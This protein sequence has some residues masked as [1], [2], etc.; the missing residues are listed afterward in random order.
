MGLNLKTN[1]SSTKGAVQ[2]CPPV[3]ALFV[4]LVVDANTPPGCK[5][6]SIRYYKSCAKCGIVPEVKLYE[7]YCRILEHVGLP[8]C[9]CV[10]SSA[11]GKPSALVIVIG[12][13]VTRV[14]TC[15]SDGLSANNKVST[16]YSC[17]VVNCLHIFMSSVTFFAMHCR[18]YMFNLSEQ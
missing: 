11:P 15:S 10:V 4:Q 3:L 7:R 14:D 1:M 9:C 17:C 13:G 5:H 16:P 2:N 18:T 12:M 6:H 8:A